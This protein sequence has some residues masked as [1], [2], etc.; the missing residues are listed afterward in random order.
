MASGAEIL[1]YIL[2]FIF[3]VGAPVG[4]WYFFFRKPASSPPAPGARTYQELKIAK[5]KHTGDD[6]GLCVSKSKPSPS[7]GA[8]T[9]DDCAKACTSSSSCNGYDFNDKTPLCNLYDS[10]PTAPTAYVS[11]TKCYAANV[12]K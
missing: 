12:T 5:P 4:V 1:G 11:H 7:A 9:S 6:H 10:A 2:L 8:K 3:L